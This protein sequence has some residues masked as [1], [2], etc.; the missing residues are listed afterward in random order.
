[1]V[2]SYNMV[3]RYVIN[4]IQIVGGSKNEDIINYTFR[5][6]R[7]YDIDIVLQLYDLNAIYS[8]EDVFEFHQDSEKQG[9]LTYRNCLGP[10]HIQKCQPG[11]RQNT[12]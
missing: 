7:L 10:K 9:K 6:L 1:M 5:D 11:T 4:I 3:A 8:N 12:Q 2:G